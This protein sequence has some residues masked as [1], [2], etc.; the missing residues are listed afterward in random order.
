MS[1]VQ[2]NNRSNR[3]NYAAMVAVLLTAGLSACQQAPREDAVQEK[4]VEQV[5]EGIFYF[6]KGAVMPAG[7]NEI[8]GETTQE[9]VRN[10]LEPSYQ[11]LQTPELDHLPPITDGFFYKDGQETKYIDIW[12]HGG[13]VDIVLY[14]YQQW[15]SRE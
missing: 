11:R 13:K 2:Q 10:I 5:H 7:L 1:P 8:T 3:M 6:P 14:G 12:Y 15:L 9:E 4:K